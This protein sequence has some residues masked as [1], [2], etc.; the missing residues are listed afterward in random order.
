MTAKPI[1]IRLAERTMPEPNSGCH[2]F[3]GCLDKYGYGLIVVSGRQQRAHRVA[4]V[5][6]CGPTPEHLPTLDHLCRVRACINPSHL[7]PV[8]RGENVMRGVGFAPLNAR[9]TTCPQ[10]HPYDDTNT[11]RK[12]NRNGRQCRQCQNAYMRAWRVRN[13]RVGH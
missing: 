5:L 7:E 10:G 11:I 4:Y 9:K 8:T 13:P 2:L 3:L 6:A 1:E 12:R